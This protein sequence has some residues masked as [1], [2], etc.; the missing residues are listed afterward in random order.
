MQIST[1][2]RNYNLHVTLKMMLNILLIILEPLD[3]GPL[4]TSLV[5]LQSFH[6]KRYTL[7]HLGDAV[8]QIN[9]NFRLEAHRTLIVSLLTKDQ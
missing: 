7:Y 8:D 6:F 3:Q 9:L 5:L 1:F 4:E 2:Y